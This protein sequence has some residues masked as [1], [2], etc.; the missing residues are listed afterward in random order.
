MLAD[1]AGPLAEGIDARR[2]INQAS[3]Q[4]TALAG[5]RGF[6]ALRSLPP[7]LAKA[8]SAA[9]TSWYDT[10]GLRNT[11]DRLVDFDLI[12]A[13][14]MWLSV[15]AVNIEG[16]NFVYFDITTHKLGLAHIMASGALPPSFPAIEIE[17]QHYWDGGTISNTP[18]QWVLRH[19]RAVL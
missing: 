15:G 13:R 4:T 2:A 6:F 1:Y 5:A 14:P 9:A 3:A 18:L 19:P 7:F 12:N 8:G 16:G 10:T 11:L 17:G